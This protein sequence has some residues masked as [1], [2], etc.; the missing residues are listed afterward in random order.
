MSKRALQDQIVEIVKSESADKRLNIVDL[1]GSL[2]E[3][4]ISIRPGQLKDL[5]SEASSRNIIALKPWTGGL[6]EVANPEYLISKN[7][8]NVLYHVEPARDGKARNL[9]DTP[10]AA[11]SGGQPLSLEEASR[12]IVSQLRSTNTPIKDLEA[13]LRSAGVDIDTGHLHDHLNLLREQ[14][15]IEFVEDRAHAT[16]PDAA[17]SLF[18]RDA[19]G[20]TRAFSGVKLK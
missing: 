3:R 10:A 9:A 16:N 6:D 8:G 11:Q 4:G 14:G 5:L 19:Q 1:H 17:S 15:L 18:N 13:G 20:V 7:Q 2:Y 12:A